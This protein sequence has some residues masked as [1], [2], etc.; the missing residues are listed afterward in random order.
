MSLRR[1]DSAD[2]WQS[3]QSG[4]VPGTL[5][6]LLRGFRLAAIGRQSRPWGLDIGL[7]H[8]IRAFPRRTRSQSRHITRRRYNLQ[9]HVHVP[10]TAAHTEAGAQ[11]GDG[12]RGWEGCG[13]SDHRW[14]W[15]VIL[16]WHSTPRPPV[17][18]TPIC[19]NAR[20]PPW[21]GDQRVDFVWISTSIIHIFSM[22]VLREI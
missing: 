20:W 16:V 15:A 2:Q 8:R 12:W 3:Y 18:P 1:L 21:A 10:C 6:P 4:P 19:D 14:P 5:G 11:G 17:R 9:T 22:D 7:K 13:S